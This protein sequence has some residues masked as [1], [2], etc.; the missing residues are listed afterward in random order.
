M[1]TSS[2][3]D[4]IICGTGCSG[5]SLVVHMIASGKF[6]D[7]KMLLIDKDPKH[8]NDRTWCFWQKGRGL[9]EPIVY[10]QWENLLFYGENFS[11]QLNFEPYVYKMIRGIDFY[12]YCFKQIRQHSNI[13][14][15]FEQVDSI[16]SEAKT[17]VV[18]K[19]QTIYADYV[20]NSILFEKPKLH[21]N[22]SW[23]LQHFKGWTIETAEN[24]F[25]ENVATLM[26]FRIYQEH[27]TAFCYVLPFT[28][29]KA[30]VEYTLFS[31]ELLPQDQYDEGL[32]HYIKN[33]L[34][35]SSYQIVEKEF[36]VIPMTDFKFLPHHNNIVY[37]G[38]A[39]GQTKGSSGYTFNFIQKHS[40]AIVDAFIKTGKPFVSNTPK[41]FNFYDSVLLRVLQEKE[42]E[43]K[44]L[45]TDLFGKNPIEKVF[46]FLDNESTLSDE[47][48]IIS[49][50]PTIP[51]LKAG[52]KQF[53]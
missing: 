27:G 50:L 4:F 25:D 36:G 46:E 43:G 44:K 16:F 22:R 7:K 51:F 13:D 15:V 14:I 52:I 17:G 19:G 18:V 33:I 48:K 32:Q 28:R 1:S 29:R 6:S 3:Y 47:L 30:L 39:G 53:I 11:K 38:T 42:I 35:L 5:L 9:F 21:K 8:A 23:L 31:D 40:K 37:I 20:F 45:F 2:Q 34:K 10:R 26:D 12:E 49:T 24:Y 41:R